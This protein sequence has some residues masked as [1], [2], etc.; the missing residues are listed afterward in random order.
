MEKVETSFE[1]SVTKDV[2]EIVT[3]CFMRECIQHTTRMFKTA[4]YR[5][6]SRKSAS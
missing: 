4:L 5:D 2:L 6:V 3:K 1:D